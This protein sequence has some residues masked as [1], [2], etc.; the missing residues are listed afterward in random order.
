M[1]SELESQ[2]RI[3]ANVVH[4]IIL[5]L[6]LVR[7]PTMY[8]DTKPPNEDSVLAIPKIVPEKFGAMSSPLPRYPAVTAPFRNRANVKIPTAQLRFSP[9]YT[10]TIIRKPGVMTAVWRKGIWIRSKGLRRFKDTHRKQ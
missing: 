10:W 6:S 8:A 5:T 2:E 9:M 1:N 7:T 3:R 4:R